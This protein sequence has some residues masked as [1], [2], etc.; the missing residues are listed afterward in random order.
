MESKR[1]QTG[2][3]PVHFC[4]RRQ[5]HRMAGKKDHEPAFHS[6]RLALGHSL[7]CTDDLTLAADGAGGK[8]SVWTVQFF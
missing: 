2:T 6:A 3:D 8:H 5:H 7:H 4:H 1:L